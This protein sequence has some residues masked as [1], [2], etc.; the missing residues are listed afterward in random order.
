MRVFGCIF[1]NGRSFRHDTFHH[2]RKLQSTSEWRK[3]VDTIEHDDSCTDIG[4]ATIQGQGPQMALDAHH[5]VHHAPC[6][7]HSI[8]HGTQ[9]TGK[10]TAIRERTI[11]AISLYFRA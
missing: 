5:I 8:K 11:R 3:N 9:R 2:M 10:L 4:K 6:N 1:P 7:Q